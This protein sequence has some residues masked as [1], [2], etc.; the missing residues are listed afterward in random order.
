MSAINSFLMVRTGRRSDHRLR[1]GPTSRGWDHLR[2][3]AHFILGFALIAF[4][5]DLNVMVLGRIGPINWASS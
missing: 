3:P 2:E 1:M 5:R 4:A